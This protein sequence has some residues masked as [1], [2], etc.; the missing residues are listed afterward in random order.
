MRPPA[1]RWRRR[2]GPLLPRCLL[3]A[4]PAL[5]SSARRWQLACEGDIAHVVVMPN[6]TIRKLET[7][8]QELFESRCA[9][10]AESGG[11]GSASCACCGCA[12]CGCV[13]SWQHSA[14]AGVCRPPRRLPCPPPAC[15][16]R[17]AVAEALKL[18]QHARTLHGED[19]NE[20]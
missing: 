3:D 15:R 7:F 6:I 17:V 16:A 11:S 9:V 14:L 5:P 10:V 4:W 20:A 19:D 2:R 1:R 13:E 8:V 18:A 12:C